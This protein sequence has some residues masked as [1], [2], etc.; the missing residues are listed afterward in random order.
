MLQFRVVANALR[1]PVQRR[2]EGHAISDR[3]LTALNAVWHSP[4]IGVNALARLLDVRQPTAS[5]LVKALAAQQLIEVRRD[6]HDRRAVNLHISADGRALLRRLP[7]GFDFGARLPLALQRMGAESVISL[8]RGLSQ[9]IE[10]LRNANANAEGVQEP[11]RRQRRPPT[12]ANP[13]AA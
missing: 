13:H 10:S 3:K 6:S 9:L 2:V 5:Q 12:G 8:E 7:A 1:A 4:G 11:E